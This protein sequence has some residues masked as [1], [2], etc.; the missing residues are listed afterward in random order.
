MGAML[1]TTLA[2]VF[3][4]STWQTVASASWELPEGVKT[5]TVNS[6]PMAFHDRGSGQ[7]V[8]LVHGAGGHD[9]RVWAQLMASPPSGLRFVA[10]SLRHLYPERWDG[11]GGDF[12]I[13]Q[14][15][16][17]LAAFIDALGVG[18]VD[19]VTHSRGG[20]VGVMVAKA[21]P[22]LIKKLVLMEGA[23][24]GLVPKPAP[25]SAKA[26][27]PIGEVRNAAAARITQG[28]IDGGLEL[29]LDR[30]QPGT[31]ARRSD[32]VRQMSRD[33]A[34]TLLAPLEVSPV[35][36]DDVAGLKM[37]V[38]LMQGE[39]TMRQMMNV[40]DATYKCLPSAERVTIPDAGHPMHLDNPAAFRADL[41]KFLSK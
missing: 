18:P 41:V 29:W 31:W 37:P 12:S 36:C 26:G 7:T 15:A 10:V 8:V 16:E 34:W 3:A 22:D 30:D 19:L 20:S 23:F 5:L 40:V 39:K 21:R 33:N 1:R 14:H 2:F 9:Y 24:A 38:M 11:K 27:R 25:A 17:D 28:D 4:A 6:Y 35:T 32:A 13:K